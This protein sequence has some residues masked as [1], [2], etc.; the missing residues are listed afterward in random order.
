[1]TSFL[2]IIVFLVRVMDLKTSFLN[3]PAVSACI[4]GICVEIAYFTG[5]TYV[6]GTSI[7]GVGIE[8]TGTEDIDTEDTYTRGTCTGIISS[9]GTEGV[10]I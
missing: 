8:G 2:E 7:E 9:T 1:M 3:S 4:G 6:K 10:C 5:S